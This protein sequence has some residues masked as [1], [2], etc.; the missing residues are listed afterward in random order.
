MFGWE[1][2]PFNSGGLGVACEG[3]AT[4]LG[5]ENVEITFVLPQTT[6][7]PELHNVSFRHGDT[8]GSHI[9]FRPVQ[10]WLLPYDTTDSYS[11]RLKGSGA[12][13]DL[14]EAVLHYSKQAAAIARQEDFDV[15]HAHDWLSFGAGLA[16]K[17]VSGKPLILHVH[18]TE[19]DRTGGKG[20]EL[21][22]KLEQEGLRAADHII[23][24][25]NFT[26]EKVSK[27]YDI[28][29]EKIDVVHNGVDFKAPAKELKRTLRHLKHNGD[30]IVLFLG[31]ITLQKGP[32]YFIEAAKQV[33]NVRPNTTF[34]MGG[35]GDMHTDMMHKAAALGI[36]EHVLF[37]GFV[38]GAD[39]HALY[40]AADLYVMPSVSEPF[41]IVALE[42]LS[43]QTPIL[44]SK[45]S[46]VSEVIAHA[47][48]TDF[49]NTKDMANKIIA[50]LDDD[51]LRTQ[52]A[53]KGGEEVKGVTWEKAAK[54]CK[55][56]YNKI[57]KHLRRNSDQ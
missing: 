23:T 33:I 46:G 20:N 14:Y 12:P 31:R 24:V 38:R 6:P 5:K 16:A 36:G 47:L 42:A 9:T 54:A 28:N 29:T 53:Q 8:C 56:I 1:F 35:S 21:I 37:P 10:S 26:K 4:A 7:T 44:I 3:L 41:G 51:T 57:I 25:S 30:S 18:A 55:N 19:F 11:N 22:H 43:K 17:R 15:I 45:Q 2:P 49:W 13:N 39:L 32:D 27:H 50:A 52:L 34:I 40:A 48:K